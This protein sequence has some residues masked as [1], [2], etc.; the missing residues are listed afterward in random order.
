MI[1][2]ENN[3]E[4]VIMIDN[5]LREIVSKTPNDKELGETIRKR[6]TLEDWNKTCDSLQGEKLNKDKEIYPQDKAVERVLNK[7]KERS[8]LGIAK[9]GTTLDREDLSIRDW[10][11]HAQEE[12]MD[13]SLYLEVLLTKIK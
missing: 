5:K 13:L 10:I 8:M 7:Y 1:I 3:L 6:I 9:Y 4:E 11:K 12:A 2:D